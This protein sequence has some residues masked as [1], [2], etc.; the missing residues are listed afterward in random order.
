MGG[1][2]R[3]HRAND[4]TTRELL[5]TAKGPSKVGLLH[6]PPSTG[7]S[8]APLIPSP[9]KELQLSCILTAPHSVWVPRLQDSSNQ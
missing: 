7:G 4:G 1:K 5:Q 8:S 3:S 6:L 2:G 9:A